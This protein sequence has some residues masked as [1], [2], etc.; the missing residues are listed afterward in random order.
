MD[1]ATPLTQNPRSHVGNGVFPFVGERL[2]LDFV[3]TDACRENTLSDALHDFDSFLRWMEAAGVIDAE[4]SSSIGRRAQQQ[5]TGAAAALTDAR[6]VRDSLRL[7]AEKG[8]NSAQV[9]AE[10]VGEM[11]RVLGR[12]AGTRRIEHRLGGGYS[13]NFVPVG[14]AFA[15]L[16]IPVVES[17]ADTLIQ[18]EL[19]RVRRCSGTG[20]KR[21]FHDG[22]RNRSRRWCDMTR[23][24][25]R[26]KAA[27]F[28]KRVATRAQ[29]EASVEASAAASAA[30][31]AAAP[32]EAPVEAPESR[33]PSL[34]TV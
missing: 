21:V 33:E 2:W 5:P 11:N 8:A 6:R 4:R 12:S 13:R 3:N 23:C 17:A 10:V 25:N 32:V 9:R 15:G 18:E 29:V 19:P 1:T 30:A 16:M 22:T 24:G 31:P 7:L 14:D 26:A 34:A 20:C 28:R 27:R